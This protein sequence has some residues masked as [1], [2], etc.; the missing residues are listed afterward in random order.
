MRAIEV[1]AVSKHYRRHA[2]LTD[3]SL[4]V[5]AG[6][7]LALI[8]HNGAGKTTLIKLLL[9]LSRPSG[10]SVSVLGA[11]PDAAHRQGRDR[12]IGFL[13]ESIALFDQ[14][15]GREA[16]GFFA[17]LKRVARS[18][19]DQL[20]DRVGL[21][22]AVDRRI[23][24]YSKGMRQRLGL[25]QAL[26]GAPKVLLLDEPT[27]GLDPALR[28]TFFDIVLERRDQGTAI[29][30]SSHQLTEIEARTDRV[31]ILRRGRL[32]AAGT[33][34]ELRAATR[35]R[36]RI[37]IAATGTTEDLAHA[38]GEAGQVIKVNGRWVELACSNDERAVLLQRLQTGMLP[39]ADLEISR[40]SLDDIYAQFGGE[41]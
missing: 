24:T 22:D 30:L 40:P 2:A 8:G 17:G 7:C 23:R 14:M 12:G 31:A 27:S 35:L 41:A 21:T 16:M 6:E 9:G 10:G 25:A 36:S 18:E 38:L 11:P 34:D 15:T 4:S 29:V 33:L 20:L 19:A 37:R 13:P 32:V 39:V 3:V 26:L 5:N 28:R 1:N